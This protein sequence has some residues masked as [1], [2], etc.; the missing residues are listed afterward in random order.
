[1]KNA[2]FPPMTNKGNW[3]VL[4]FALGLVLLVGGY[5]FLHLLPLRF[6]PDFIIKVFSFIGITTGVVVPMLGYLSYPRVHN[7]KVFLAGYL[8]GVA[9]LAFFLLRPSGFISLPVLSS[10]F[11]PGLYLFMIAA[12]FMSTV[13]PTFLKYRHT[14]YITIAILTGDK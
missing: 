10:N 14:K 5:W 9:A 1:M 7:L 3:G 4:L 2:K 8:T 11:I 6:D 12:I 13:L